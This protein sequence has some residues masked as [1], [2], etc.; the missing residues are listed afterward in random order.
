[1]NCKEFKQWLLT[2]DLDD[3]G[4]LESAQRHRKTCRPCERLFEMD[5][6]LDGAIEAELAAEPTTVDVLSRV[7]RRV[8]AGDAVTP[9]FGPS[10]WRVVVP[11]LAVAAALMVA[12]VNHRSS[13]LPSP[14]DIGAYALENHLNPE[15]QTMTFT[16][17]DVADVPRWFDGWVGFGDGLAS[18]LPAGLV[19]VGG[20]R[21]HIG[22]AP[23]AYLQCKERGR[24]VSL[25]IINGNH[26][27][28][29]LD[30]RKP[31]VYRGQGHTVEIW[32][33]QDV[34]CAIVRET[35]RPSSP[36]PA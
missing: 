19:P 6:G 27:S 28:P 3:R 25:F 8:N 9:V 31:Y 23:A 20:R 15:L 30:A 2:K 12:V 21:C 18:L 26:L 33:T 7:R 36:T 1:M 22:N 24:I 14:D 35:D 13:S 4:D 29:K 10:R 34:I 5:H 17:G 32:Q 11:A 16:V